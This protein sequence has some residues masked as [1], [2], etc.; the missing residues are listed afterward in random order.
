MNTEWIK[1]KHGQRVYAVSH[2]KAVVRGDST[3]DTDLKK[4]ENHYTA[5]GTTLSRNMEYAIIGEW[6]DGNPDNENRVGYFVSLD[7]EDPTKIVKATK[8]STVVGIISY[9]PAFAGNAHAEMYNE[10]KK[11]LPQYAYVSI[12][13]QIPVRHDE[14]IDEVGVSVM[15]NK[16]GVAELSE[17]GYTVT[18]IVDE[19]YALVLV[20]L[21][22][23]ALVE[24]NKALGKYVE[25]VGDIALTDAPIYNTSDESFNKISGGSKGNNSASLTLYGKDNEVSG[26]FI[27]EAG[28]DT[29]QSHLVGQSSGRLQ[30]TGKDIV[31]S[32]NNMNADENGNVNVIESEDNCV[33]F[34]DGT[35]I[36][37]VSTTASP[38]GVTFSF[39]KPFAATPSVTANMCQSTSMDNAITCNATTTSVTFNCSIECAIYCIAIGRWK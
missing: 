20:E 16:N 7:A 22:S 14:T 37:Y 23:Q 5:D 19:N 34:T 9:A 25:R 18:Q 11:L 10:D 32:I 21:N 30:W 24:M 31:R 39:P 4:I 6:A 36:C 15:P 2:A 27:L 38:D 17:F 33:R 12:L 1:N 29:S 26:S 13:G 28:N 35:Q 3:V 8:D